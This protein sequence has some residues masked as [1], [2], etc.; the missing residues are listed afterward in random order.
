MKGL[1]SVL[2]VLLM[3]P[4]FSMPALAEN[5]GELAAPTA[6]PAPGSYSESQTVTLQ[7]ATPGARIYFTTDGSDPTNQSHLYTEPITVDATTTVKA[8]AIRGNGNDR[9]G[10]GKSEVVSMTYTIESR[11]DIAAKFLK[12]QYKEMPY[13]LYVPENYDPN[14][15]YPL[16]LFLHGGGERGTDNEKQLLA[17]D[18][19]IVWAKPENQRKNPAFVLAPQARDTPDGGFG[20]TRDS[21]NELN[22]DRVFQFSEDLGTAY[23]ILQQVRDEYPID[24]RRLYST[25]LSQG[26]FG[27]F[28]LNTAYPDLFA[29]MVPIAAGGDPEKADR[30]VD[31]PMWVFHAVDDGVIPV[32]YSRDIVEAIKAIGGDPIYTEYPTGGHASW[33]PA[34][35]NQEMIDWMFKQVK[36]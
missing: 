21:N 22:L 30:I 14:Q 24:S 32:S 11:E 9:M 20:L 5:S 12:L 15:S 6:T 23:E 16:V 25:G 13:R 1:I 35:A 10:K 3:L 8:V 26:G 29:A 18:G 27:T 7:T 4:A 33:E 19:A 28:N 36:P 34:Y 31:K 2:C 17:N